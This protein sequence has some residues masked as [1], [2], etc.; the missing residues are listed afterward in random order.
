[1]VDALAIMNKLHITILPSTYLFFA[2]AMGRTLKKQRQLIGPT[3]VLIS[4]HL[5]AQLNVC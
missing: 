1:M 4:E 5:Y 2:F 3:M